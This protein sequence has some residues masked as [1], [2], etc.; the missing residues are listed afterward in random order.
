[1]AMY[2]WLILLLLKK[3][4]KKNHELTMNVAQKHFKETTDRGVTLT[5]KTLHIPREKIWIKSAVKGKCSNYYERMMSQN[6]RCF[7]LSTYLNAFAN[8]TLKSSSK[9]NLFNSLLPI[10]E[11]DFI[12]L[13]LFNATLKELSF[14]F[15]EEFILQHASEAVCD[16]RSNGFSEVTKKGF[17]TWL[18]FIWHSTWW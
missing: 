11:L 13:A 17:V 16:R 3:I 15:L 10:S 1:M 4:K 5:I 6:K 2:E 18:V 8:L 14:L 7:T 12:C 9:K